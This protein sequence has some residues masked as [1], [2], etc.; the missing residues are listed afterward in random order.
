[1][2]LVEIDESWEDY[3]EEE[4]RR[5]EE[6]FPV[7]EREKV[8]AQVTNWDTA[9]SKRK[10]TPMIEWELTIVEDPEYS[11]KTLIHR[12][13]TVGKG[14]FMLKAFYEAGGLKLSGK[15]FDPELMLG[16]I[17]TVFL[18]IIVGQ[19]GANLGRKFTQ[20]DAVTS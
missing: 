10:G 12:T 16:K 20:I 18:S 2:A 15:G 3:E 19:E 9:V 7:I 13:M 8:R 4:E 14:K 17:V 6:A 5:R 1:M 11:G